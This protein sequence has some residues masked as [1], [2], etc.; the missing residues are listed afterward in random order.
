MRSFEWGGGTKS[1]GAI[2]SKRT[3]SLQPVSLQ[4]REQDIPHSSWNDPRGRGFFLRSRFF[5]DISSVSFSE[6]QAG[7]LGWVLLNATLFWASVRLL[8][9]TWRSVGCAY[10]GVGKF[11][12]KKKSEAKQRKRIIIAS[13]R[14]HWKRSRL[15]TFSVRCLGFCRLQHPAASAGC[16]PGVRTWKRLPREKNFKCAKPVSHPKPKLP[17]W[18]CWPGR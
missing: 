2:A 13:P 16:C 12:G 17:A 4:K 9:A 5:W 10:G 1:L 14:Q 7:S 11:L 8:G 6:I 3:K 15:P 18:F